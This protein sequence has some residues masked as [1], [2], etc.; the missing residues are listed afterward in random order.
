MKYKFAKKR[1][2]CPLCNCKHSFA[3]FEIDGQFSE[4]YGYC[5]ACGETIFADSIS[6]NEKK[7]YYEKPELPT[8]ELPKEDFEDLFG[9]INDIFT[10]EI[11][12][13]FPKIIKVL[14][15]YRVISINKRTGFPLIDFTG[16]I[17]SIKIFDYDKTLHKKKFIDKEGVE[18][19]SIFWYH[20]GKVN[21]EKYQF[22]SCWFGE[23]LIFNS[24]YEYIGIVES[25]KTAL[26]ANYFLPNVLF[27]ATGSKG[28]KKNAIYKGIGDK[29]TIFYPDYDA[30]QEWTEFVKDCHNPNWQISKICSQMSDK[31][32]I[33]DILL[34]TDPLEFVEKL[35]EE[36]TKLYNPSK[37]PEE[38]EDPLK[39][40]ENGIIDENKKPL[41]PILWDLYY[42]DDFED[43]CIR[44]NLK[45]D[46]IK[47]LYFT[48]LEEPKFTDKSELKKMRAKYQN[49]F[50]YCN[51]LKAKAIRDCFDSLIAQI[52]ISNKKTVCE[53]HLQSIIKPF[54]TQLFEKAKGRL[55]DIYDFTDDDFC[56][57]NFFIAQSKIN[58]DVSLN[59]SL[60]LW[61]KE[62]FTGKTTFGIALATAMNG[63]DCDFMRSFTLAEEMQF[64][65]FSIPNCSKY[66]VTMLDEGFFSN[67]GKVYD[68]LK[69]QITSASVRIEFK[70]KNQQISIPAKRNYIFTSN[71]DISEFVQ[72]EEERRFCSIEMKKFKRNVKKT[73]LFKIVFDYVK[74]VNMD[75]DM[76]QSKY[77]SQYDKT[78]VIGDIFNEINQLSEMIKKNEF[79]PIQRI[80]SERSYIRLIEFAQ[81]LRD[82]NLVNRS[83]DR[84]LKRIA[85]GVLTKLYGE[86]DSNCRWYFSKLQENTTSQLSE[87][88]IINE[89]I[90]NREDILPY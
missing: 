18:R 71:N 20:T 31:E 70:H 49:A 29:K 72:D 34:G 52:D 15:K 41:N 10:Q 43:Y 45:M 82:G 85:K 22:K 6:E 12:L 32:D 77:L 56:K 87:L 35:N 57:L 58:A 26:I 59:K 66:N 16:K 5:H 40:E 42:Y 90:I 9:E 25:E 44:K 62:K 64:E 8:W 23:H 53:K 88:P 51:N 38:N 27:L 28:T 76:L 86:A 47:N 2:E 54:D 30:I 48:I 83:N 65:R 11:I 68:D 7:E 36:L 79:F 60:Y 4:Q 75:S 69:R 33:A 80:E 50:F 61:S 3:G 1:T 17:R 78:K 37:E 84:M 81:M 21:E 13:K 73:E 39:I 19:T 24:E 63:F 67:M 14:K 46:E 74:E 55:A 89:T